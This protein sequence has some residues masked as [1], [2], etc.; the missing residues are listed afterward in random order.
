MVSGKMTSMRALIKLP[1]CRA[2]PLGVVTVAVMLLLAACSGGPGGLA[3]P[4]SPT[5][6][7]PAPSSSAAVATG[8]P[9]TQVA[10]PLTELQQPGEPVVKIP[11]PAGW[12]PTPGADTQQLRAA[13]S[14]PNLTVDN[15]PPSITVAVTRATGEVQDVIDRSL[16]QISSVGGRLGAQQNRTTCGFDAA[17][18]VFTL[19]PAG[20]AYTTR[21]GT[22]HVVAVPA[23]GTV[24]VVSVAVQS[25]DPTNP[26]FA[27]DQNTIISGLQVI[28]PN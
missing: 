14:N 27:A 5:A 28:A 23:D 10:A 25:A 11:I 19:P 18:A 13:F 15:F 4:L 20:R 16:E 6:S 7:T 3:D 17:T 2:A 12:V 8:G 22:L 24:F 9:C 26:T 21:T 1:C